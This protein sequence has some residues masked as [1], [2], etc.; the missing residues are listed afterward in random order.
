MAVSV[1]LYKRIEGISSKINMNDVNLNGK[2]K[3]FRNR[4]SRLLDFPVHEIGKNGSIVHVLKRSDPVEQE[5]K[6]EPMDSV[7]I[8]EVVTALQAALMNPAHRNTVE[9]MMSRPE[10]I[11][12]LIAATPGLDRDP[13]ALAMLQDAE[14]LA[15]V[16]D[17]DLIHRV[18]ERHPCLSHAAMMVAAAVS[19]E[20]TRMSNQTAAVSSGTYSLDQMSDEDDDGVGSSALRPPTQPIT[21][22]QLAAALAA[23]GGGP[24][25]MPLSD[26]NQSSSSSGHPPR[27]I[28]TPD[29]LQ[30]AVLQAA[31][32]S[33]EGSSAPT[34]EEY[35]VS[36]VALQ[37]LHDMGITDEAQ[38]RQALIMTSGDIEAALE[39]L[40]GDG[41]P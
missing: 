13:I 32:N 40:F 22:S 31:G 2:V 38:A 5:S 19:E 30:Q 25:I 6:P 21:T 9:N 1:V 24:P 26:Q 37:Q 28:I 7:S 14:L 27:P 17:Q 39:I 11:D 15:I 20:N 18:I 36:E 16:A 4:A 29:F 33:L 3:E 34:Q 23:A 10:T 35:V 12:S 8:Q 41:Q